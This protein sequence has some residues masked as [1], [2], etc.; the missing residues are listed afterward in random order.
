MVGLNSPGI[1]FAS[2]D[3]KYQ[4]VSSLVALPEYIPGLG[5]LYIDP[6]TLPA[7]PFLA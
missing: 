5:V 1:I 4:N 2:P 7:G 6:A 3:G